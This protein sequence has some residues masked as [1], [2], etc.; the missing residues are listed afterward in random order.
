MNKINRHSFLKQSL[1]LGVLAAIAPLT[2]FLLTDEENNPAKNTGFKE[3]ILQ[4]LLKANDAEVSRLLKSLPANSFAR[5]IGY[6][7]A[8]LTASYCSG[9]S[10]YHQDRTIVSALERIAEVLLSHQS[11]DGTVSIGNLESPPDTAFILEPL[12]AAIFILT[13]KKSP[14]LNPVIEKMKT[15]ILKSGEALATGGVHTPNHRWVISAALARINKLYPDKKYIARIEDW[16]GE[17]I[18]IDSDGHYPERSRL[19]AGVENEAFITMGR[20]LNKPELFEAV[21]KNL[22]TTYYYMEPNG[23]LVTADSRRQDQYAGKNIVSYYLLYRYLANRDNNG[24]FSAIAK[25]IEG[26]NGFEEEVLN[27]SLFYFLENP[28]LQNELPAG[29]PPPVNYEKLFTGSKLL[30]IRR[31]DTTATLF[32]GVDWPLIIASGRSNSP[33]FFSYRKGNAVLKYLRLSSGF[34]SMGYFYSDGLKKEGNK[35]MLY[36]KLEVPYYQPLS[37]ELRNDKGDYSLSPS[38]DGRFWNKMSFEKRPVSNIK[39]LETA[40]T[41]KENNGR[42]ELTFR[43]TGMEGIAVTIELCFKEGGRLSGVTDVND[44]EDNHFLEKGYGKYEYKGDA[45]EF[46]PGTAAGKNITRLEGER[47]STHFGTLRTEG[48]HVYLTGV[49]PFE[50]TLSFY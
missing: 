7:F 41:L 25:L 17:G 14:A 47:Y 10:V 40:V 16:M 36:K 33:N 26:Y 18:F 11:A 1:N 39:T 5:K 50:H 42:N 44:P 30:R 19:Y 12:C 23:D 43:V 32:G 49:T 35:Y 34:F 2:D 22:D 48:M 15:F 13:E 29:T 28:L 46:G 20:L 27:N 9:S 8:V 6:D 21:R 31:G 38:T 45:I 24:K 3:D 4:R 37:K